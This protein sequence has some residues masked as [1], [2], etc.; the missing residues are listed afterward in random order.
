MIVKPCPRSEQNRFAVD[1]LGDVFGGD[2]Q[3]P[4][5]HHVNPAFQ[6]VLQVVLYGRLLEQARPVAH[7]HERVEVA[8]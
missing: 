8:A 1:P 2:A 7:V 5:G 3:S 4:G 6:Q